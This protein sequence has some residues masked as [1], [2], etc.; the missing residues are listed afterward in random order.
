MYG[1]TV[2]NRETGIKEEA[3][4]AYCKALYV[5]WLGK[6]RESRTLRPGIDFSIAK[7]KQYSF[8]Y[9]VK[10]P[11]SRSCSCPIIDRSWTSQCAVVLGEVSL[12]Q[13]LCGEVQ[14]AECCSITLPVFLATFKNYL[15]DAQS[16][17]LRDTI[18]Q[19]G[20]KSNVSD[21]C[22]KTNPVHFSSTLLS[23]PKII[24]NLRN[25]IEKWL[26][27]SLCL[28][29]PSV[30]NWTTIIGGIWRNLIFWAFTEIC[31]KNIVLV[32]IRRK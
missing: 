6:T 7:K 28:C 20:S 8:S 16:T 1:K 18:S 11:G 30:R 26:L 27:A 4:A 17:L 25:N 14:T 31:Q 19:Q 24:Q 3:N 10:P 13:A 15:R 5:K 2:T 21:F 23:M 12:M 29:C 32:N 9:G 22:S